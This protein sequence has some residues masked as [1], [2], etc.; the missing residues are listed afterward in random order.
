MYNQQAIME[1]EHKFTVYKHTNK[2]NGKIYV[3]ITGVGVYNR[4][5]KNGVNY[6]KDKGRFSYAIRKYGWSNFTHE[7][8]FE[9][10]TRE[11]ACQKE[12]Q[13]IKEW[14]LQDPNIGYNINSGGDLNNYNVKHSQETKNK[15]SKA[16]SNIIIGKYDYYGKLIETYCNLKEVANFLGMHST[17]LPIHLKNNPHKELKGFYWKICHKDLN[18]PL[19]LNLDDFEGEDWIVSFNLLGGLD[20][21]I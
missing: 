14:N 4:W 10:L 13:L 6:L 15:I 7:I 9:N 17:T 11:D 5:G 19:Q 3:G 20:V 1:D 16:N 21:Y 2:I 8:L 18:L 12:I